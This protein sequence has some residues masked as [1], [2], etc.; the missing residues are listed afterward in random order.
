MDLESGATLKAV[1][2]ELIDKATAELVP[3]LKNALQGAL[4]GLTVEIT[5]KVTSKSGVAANNSQ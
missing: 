5:I 1:T 3:A 2:D 4:D